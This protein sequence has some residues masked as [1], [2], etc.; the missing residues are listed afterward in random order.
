M[1]QSFQRTTR[2]KYSHDKRKRK[3]SRIG[4]N[5]SSRYKHRTIYT[6][7]SIESN[8]KHLKWKI[9]WTDRNTSWSMKIRWLQ[10]ISIRIMQQCLQPRSYREL[11]KR[12]TN[13]LSQR[14]ETFQL[15]KTRGITLIQIAAK[16]YNLMLLNRIRPE[17]EI[18]EKKSNRISYK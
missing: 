7:K 4:N 2:K 17:I 18:F 15:L 10:R 12:F 14:K 5:Q 6:R 8:K 13:F 11:E 1:A 3:W 16:I 9:S